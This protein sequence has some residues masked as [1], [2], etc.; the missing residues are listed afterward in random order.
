MIGHIARSNEARAAPVLTS[1]PVHALRSLRSSRQPPAI[2]LQAP[3][4]FDR[5]DRLL[6]RHLRLQSWFAPSCS[7]CRRKDTRQPPVAAPAAP[8]ASRS[9][10]APLRSPSRQIVP[11]RQNRRFGQPNMVLPLPL[12]AA[13]SETKGC[14]Q[15]RIVRRA[16]YPPPP[17]SQPVPRQHRPWRHHRPVLKVQV[18]LRTRTAA[19]G[20]GDR[21]CCCSSLLVSL[22]ETG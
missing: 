15:C 3:D 16:R 17:S 1:M 20:D 8:P 4:I 21:L 5:P 22:A 18:S 7:R 2:P 13:F 19:A 9:L 11:R 6:R 12:E 10:P 14:R